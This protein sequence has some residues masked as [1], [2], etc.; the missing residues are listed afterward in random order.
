MFTLCRSFCVRAVRRCVGEGVHAN[1][2]EVRAASR[3]APGMLGRA[4]LALVL[5]LLLLA[6]TALA[7]GAPPTKEQ[8]PD[9]SSCMDVCG[10]HAARGT[11][12]SSHCSTRD[13]LG[14][15]TAKCC[16]G[17]GF[18][19]PQ[20]PCHDATLPAQAA[21]PAASAAL[22]APPA[23]LV[24]KPSAREDE[25]SP[26]RVQKPQLRPL[27]LAPPAGGGG[28][29]SGERA[30]SRASPMPLRIHFPGT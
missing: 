27:I 6:V 16:D 9:V 24:P 29:G 18:V 23:P 4:P 25:G 8:C 10:E 22:Q 28:A 7:D 13:G 3:R 14:K 12:H 19:C 20:P 15:Y 21:P 5:Q 30:A 17:T 2:S 11:F 26:L 1:T